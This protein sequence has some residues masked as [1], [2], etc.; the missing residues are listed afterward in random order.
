MSCQSNST[1]VCLVAHFIETEAPEL[2]LKMC[3]VARYYDISS[4]ANRGYILI[5]HDKKIILSHTPTLELSVELK[6]SLPLELSVV[7]K[8]SVM[9]ELSVLLKLSVVLK[10]WLFPYMLSCLC[11]CSCEKCFADFRDVSSTRSPGAQCSCIRRE[12]RHQG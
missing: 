9:L 8:P 1:A 11:L 7:L 4:K 3:A 10:L 6:L 2:Q 12:Q 5:I